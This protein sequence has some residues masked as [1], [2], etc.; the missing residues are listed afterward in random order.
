MSQQSG[1]WKYRVLKEERGVGGG[2]E[3]EKEEELGGGSHFL[4]RGLKDLINLNR[5]LE[6]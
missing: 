6:K 1:I 5:H 2:E 4:V 3:R